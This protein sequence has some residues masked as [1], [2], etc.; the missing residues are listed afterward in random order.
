M[1]IFAGTKLYKPPTCEACGKIESDCDC[2]PPLPEATAP[3]K[4]TAR[5]QVENRKRGK[6]VTTIRGLA[7]G[8]PE[9]HFS[10]LLTQIKNHCGAGGSIKDDAIEVQG[11]Q[12]ERLRA[13]LKQLGFKVK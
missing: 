3:N 7:Q 5:L 13:F 2:V 10:R 1:S 4:Q 11:D 9:P 8:H 12:L 6:Q